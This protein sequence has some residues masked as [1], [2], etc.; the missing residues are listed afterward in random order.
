MSEHSK[1]SGPRRRR[2]LAA[3]WVLAA[4]LLAATVGTSV[5]LAATPASQTS[6]RPGVVPDKLSD[7]KAIAGQFNATSCA[8]VWTSAAYSISLVSTGSDAPYC[9]VVPTSHIGIPIATANSAL[10]FSGFSVVIQAD[11]F[12]DIDFQVWNAGTNMTGQSGAGYVQFIVTKA[13]P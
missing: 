7:I 1:P 13:T 4:A 9:Q 10:A 5:A 3:A 2:M 6:T 11:T 12:P 8:Q